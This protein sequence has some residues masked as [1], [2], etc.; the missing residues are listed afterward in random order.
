[1]TTRNFVTG[2]ILLVSLAGCTAHNYLARTSIEAYRMDGV[3]DPDPDA[4][5][6]SI[7]APYRAELSAEM[8]EVIGEAVVTLEKA[9]P[10][11]SLNNWF[12]DAFRHMGE[13]TLGRPV[14]LAYQNYGGVR[15]NSLAS[16]PI[17][18][19]KIF[20]L[21]PFDNQM[22]VVVLDSAQLHALCDL[23]AATGGEPV[24]GTIKFGILE[25]K[26]YMIEVHGRPLSNDRTFTCV[27]PDYVANS[28]KCSEILTGAPRE[29]RAVL[30]RD[31]IIKEVEWL[32]DNG[33]KVAA[34]ADDRIY[35]VND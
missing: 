15:L 21:M 34:Q 30:I 32:T 23:I 10:A 35:F 26:A 18:R 24:S 17:T 3:D 29:D 22:A 4:R 11:G 28:P 7:I 33:R 5:I 20:E 13:L 2:L 8:D 1:M 14:D 31:L 25:D 19:G 27:L 12:A 6:D 16:G 9:K